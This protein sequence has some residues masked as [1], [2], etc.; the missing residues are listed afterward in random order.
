MLKLLFLALS[1]KVISFVT[2]SVKNS[3][4]K[5]EEATIG[6][7]GFGGSGFGGS[8]FGNSGF[9][10]SGFCGGGFWDS[11]SGGSNADNSNVFGRAV[12][13]LRHKSQTR[14]PLL[15]RLE[16]EVLASVTCRKDLVYCALWIPKGLLQAFR[17]ILECD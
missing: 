4:P 5:E 7:S 11:A 15:T 12:S 9:R 13:F 14:S 17:G 8:G 10:N 16:T 6:G 2:Y 1:A 3:Q